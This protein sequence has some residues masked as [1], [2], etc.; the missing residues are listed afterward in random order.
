MRLNGP[1]DAEDTKGGIYP[2]FPWR[3]KT[4]RHCSTA[5]RQ[6][7]SRHKSEATSSCL[8]GARL[9][10]R[11]AVVIL[12]P[13]RTAPAAQC[14]LPSLSLM[15]SE[16]GLYLVWDP[17]LSSGPDTFLHGLCFC[18]SRGPGALRP[19]QICLRRQSDARGPRHLKPSAW[20]EHL[21]SHL[22]RGWMGV[23]LT[24][25]GKG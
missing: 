8:R 23:V 6:K 24:C 14:H 3:R 11:E 9:R 20:S 19:D 21:S 13:Q 10:D 18:S 4:C 7:D 22:L 16:R 12:K 5:L 1:G 17:P 2:Y 25:P 15:T